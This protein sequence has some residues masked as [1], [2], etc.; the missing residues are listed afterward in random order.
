MGPESLGAD[1]MDGS[2]SPSIAPTFSPSVH[3]L[4]TGLAWAFCKHGSLRYLGSFFICWGLKKQE[5]EAVSLESAT[6]SLLPYFIIHGSQ[7]VHP[8]SRGHRSH[9]LTVGVSENL[10]AG[11]PWLPSLGL[12]VFAKGQRALYG[13]GH[14]TRTRNFRCGSQPT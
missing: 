3:S 7:R 2:L 12:N 6:V 13:E 1:S 11:F 10:W 4:F 8:L 5:L 9:L 14:L